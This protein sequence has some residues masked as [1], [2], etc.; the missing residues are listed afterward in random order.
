M[1]FYWFNTAAN[2]GNEVA[3]YNLGLVCY[4]YEKGVKGDEFK[5]F[6]LY[7]ESAKQ[8]YLKAQERVA[9]CYE[10]GLELRLIKKR[11]LNC[12]Y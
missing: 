5:A 12:I 6:E 3:L 11:H 4:E 7:K 10:W 9:Y 1:A 2:N 8:R